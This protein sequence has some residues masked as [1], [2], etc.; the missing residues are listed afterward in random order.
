MSFLANPTPVGSFLAEEGALPAH[1]LLLLLLLLPPLRG[2]VT[3]PPRVYPASSRTNP[4]LRRLTWSKPSCPAPS[5][6][7]V[8]LPLCARSAQGVSVLSQNP[9]LVSYP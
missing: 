4:K 6:P 5:P 7:T 9:N 1:L 3:P 8:P 2:P